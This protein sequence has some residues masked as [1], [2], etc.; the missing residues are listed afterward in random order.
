[1]TLVEQP[2][3]TPFAE[4]C[5]PVL[6]TERLV[7]RAPRIEDVPAVAALANNHR[8]AEMTA[9]LPYPYR[10]SDARTFVETLAQGPDATTFALFLKSEG[11]QEF[12]G[13]C[14]FGRRPPETVH[15]IGY[16]IGEPFWGKGIATEAMRAVIDYAFSE[17]DI[18][19][20]AA[21]ARVVNPASRRVLEKCAFQWSGVGLCRVKA[22]SASVPVDRFQLDRRTWA[23]LRAWGAAAMPMRREFAH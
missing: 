13:M 17:T 12:A 10:L 14:S 19:Q 23:S 21:A 2:L 3:G 6:E 4:S 20:L 9:N 15:E 18:D 11:N 7:L 8:I 22:L 5:I 16:W 1:M